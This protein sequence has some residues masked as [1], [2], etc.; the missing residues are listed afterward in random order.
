M[1]GGCG[2]FAGLGGQFE[3]SFGTCWFDVLDV[4]GCDDMMDEL[5]YLGYTKALASEMDNV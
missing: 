2:C 4:S 1:G 5:Q 3:R